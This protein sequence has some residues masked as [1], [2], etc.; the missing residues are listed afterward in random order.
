MII[1]VIF[2]LINIC[3]IM[4]PWNSTQNRLSCGRPPAVRA[5]AASDRRAAVHRQNRCLSTRLMDQ[6]GERARSERERSRL[7]EGE[8]GEETL[9]LPS[10]PR[11]DF[12]LPL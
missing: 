6:A 12:G 1:Y 7:S 3:T 10:S 5:W 8:V 4:K 11:A 2:I 9:P